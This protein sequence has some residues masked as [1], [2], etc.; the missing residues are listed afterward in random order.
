L[1]LKLTL[2]KISK[3][4]SRH[5]R[6]PPSLVPPQKRSTKC[7]D[8]NLG[9]IVVHRTIN[10]ETEYEIGNTPSKRIRHARMQKGWMIKTLAAKAGITS[11]CLSNIER[12]ITS[13]ENTTLRKICIA[14][15]QPIWFLGCFESMPEDTFFQRLEKARCY[16]GHTKLEM[17]K[18]IGVHVRAIFDWKAKEPCEAVKIKALLYLQILQQV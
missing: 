9:E 2:T 13:V 5:G 16:H 10:Q 12:Q 8:N 18:D 14:L 3:N 1:I 11:V 17:A 4:V 7:V 6:P 15:E